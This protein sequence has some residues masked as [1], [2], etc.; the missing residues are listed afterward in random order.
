MNELFEE[1]GVK[2]RGFIKKEIESLRQRVNELEKQLETERLRLAA[3]GAAALGYFNGCADEYKSASLD[4]V[5][6]LS[7]Q[8]AEERAITSDM[9]QR[10]VE[11]FRKQKA[12]QQQLTTTSYDTTLKEAIKQ[13]KREA[14]LEAVREF[15]RMAHGVAGA[16]VFPEK[17]RRMAEEIKDE[18]T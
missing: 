12:L 9:Q 15:E 3:C 6:A 4:D 14:L 5:L 7:Q 11:H 8:L 13:A 17:L 1:M 18:P 16:G 10:E 2:Y